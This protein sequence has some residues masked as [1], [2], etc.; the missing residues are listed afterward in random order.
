VVLRCFLAAIEGD[1]SEDFAA[2]GLNE[3]DMKGYVSCTVHKM[4]GDMRMI[5]LVSHRKSIG[6]FWKGTTAAKLPCAADGGVVSQGS[7]SYAYTSR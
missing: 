6:I 3:Y 5:G 7:Q 4:G 2:E 1:C